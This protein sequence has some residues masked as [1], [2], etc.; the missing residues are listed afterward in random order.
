[1]E[2]VDEVDLTHEHSSEYVDGLIEKIE[3]LED[4]KITAESWILTLT[5]RFDDEVHAEAESIAS[6]AVWKQIILNT[7]NNTIK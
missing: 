2:P 4:Y 7:G 5:H 6:K 3:I 1:M